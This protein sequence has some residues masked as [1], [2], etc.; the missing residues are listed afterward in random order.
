MQTAVMMMTS[1]AQQGEKKKVINK[2]GPCL[3]IAIQQA[4]S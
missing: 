1:E 2:S 4:P 3:S